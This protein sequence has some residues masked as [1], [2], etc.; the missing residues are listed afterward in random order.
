[1]EHITVEELLDTAI[2]RAGVNDFGDSGFKEGLAI[3]VDSINNNEHVIEDR[4]YMLRE[5]FLRMLTNRLWRTQDI[6]ENPEI[7]DQKIASPTVIISFPRTGSTKLQQV[8]EAM[9][10]FYQA[11]GW[12]I[13]NPARIPGMADGG[14]AVRFA[15]A[16][17]FYEWRRQASPELGKLHP[18]YA[19]KADE[20][21]EMFYETFRFAGMALYY[22]SDEFSKWANALDISGIYDYLSDQLKYLHWQFNRENSRPW[23]LKSP[24]FMGFEKHLA[25]IFPEGFKIIYLHR[26]PADIIP[27]ATKVMEAQKT[28]HFDIPP[29]SQKARDEM[30]AW[31]TG[32]IGAHMRWRDKNPSADILDLSFHEVTTDSLG[33]CEKICDFVG[34]EFTDAMSQRILQWD[35]EHPRHKHGKSKYSLEEYGL[36]KAQVNE[37]FSDYLDRFGDYIE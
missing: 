9:D 17:E 3:L 34:T 4:L 33:T 32:A 18:T 35:E 31:T 2:Q 15:Q 5:Q 7:L 11:P 36:N 21:T 10:H 30:L 28:L 22:C 14:Q 20:E 27:S 12:Q 29:Q 8:L 37:Y 1:M 6:S 19:D 24:V 16:K 25:R 23:L 26:S 13:Y